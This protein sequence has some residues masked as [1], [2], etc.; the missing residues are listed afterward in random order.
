MIP[1]HCGRSD[2]HSRGSSAH[3]PEQRAAPQRARCLLRF[4]VA[5][6]RPPAISEFRLSAC[7]AGFPVGAAGPPQA[8]RCGM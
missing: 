8:R 3:P 6:R 5:L 7:R 2:I 1:P 4:I